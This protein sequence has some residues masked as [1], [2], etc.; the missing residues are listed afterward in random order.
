MTRSVGRGVFGL[1]LV[2]TTPFMAHASSDEPAG[3]NL[4]GT[5]FMDGFGRTD[6]GFVYQQYFQIEHYNAINDSNGHSVPTFRGTDINSVVSLN[7]LIY[8]SP[9]H[10]LGGALGVDALLPIV[11]LNA[12]FSSTSP[13]KLT[14]NQGVTLGDLTWGPFLQMPPVIAGGRPVFAERFEFDVISPIGAYNRADDINPGSGFWSLNPFWAM[15]FLPTPNIEFSTR[16]NYLHNFENNS[17]A[18]GAPPF[19]A[20]DAVWTNFAASYKVLPS[21]NLGINGYYFQQ[22]QN[23]SVNGQTRPKTRTTNFSL[24][25]GAMYQPDAHNTFFVNAYLPVIERDTTHGFHFV[26][27]WIHEF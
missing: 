26:F 5:S 23:D 17:P 15:T 4:G 16:L 2:L 14:A 27:R 20:G 22:I 13:A 3:I 25:L 19:R 11:N 12:A 18:V 6:P 7:Q 21:L 1:V 10:L 8:V 24:G 9:Y